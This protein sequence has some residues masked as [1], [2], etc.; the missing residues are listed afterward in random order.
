MKKIVWLI[1]FKCPLNCSV[2]YTVVYRNMMLYPLNM[3]FLHNV[4]CKVILESIKIPFI[5]KRNIN[6]WY[7]EKDIF[8]KSKNVPLIEP[9]IFHVQ[10]GN[11]VLQNLG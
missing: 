7:V 11:A 5:F 3:S 4:L 10:N 1:F 9:A 6:N 8:K 2:N